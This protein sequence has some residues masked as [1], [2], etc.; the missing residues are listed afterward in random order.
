MGLQWGIAYPPLVGELVKAVHLEYQLSSAVS[1]WNQRSWLFLSLYHFTYV[2]CGI[3]VSTVTHLTNN[4][5]QGVTFT[6]VI[7][8]TPARCVLFCLDRPEK[9]N[10]FSFT[11]FQLFLCP[12]GDW[13]KVSWDDTFIY[14]QCYNYHICSGATAQIFDCTLLMPNS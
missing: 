10:Y 5:G 12:K 3:T 7:V 8:I 11:P 1:L 2:I 14:L 4:K 9:L 6:F 13:L